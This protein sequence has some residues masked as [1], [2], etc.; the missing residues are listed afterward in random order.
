[1]VGKRRRTDL[2]IGGGLVV[3]LL[4]LAGCEAPDL[5]LEPESPGGPALAPPPVPPP[6]LYSAHLLPDLPGGAGAKALDI[7]DAGTVVGWADQG[8]EHRAVQWSLGTVTALATPTKASYGDP[9]ILKVNSVAHGINASGVAV[10]YYE[11]DRGIQG[12][13]DTAVRWINSSGFVRLYGATGKPT[14]A[15]AINGSGTVVGSSGD[16]AFRWN[17]A[18]QGVDL[19]PPGAIASVANDINDAGWA[20]GTATGTWGTHAYL[21]PPSGS[22]LDLTPFLTED[23]SYG[24]GINAAAVVVGSVTQAAT[25]EAFRRQGGFAILTIPSCTGATRFAEKVSDLGRVA[26]RCFQPNMMVRAWTLR[27]TA[28]QLLPL[29]PAAGWSEAFGVNGCGTVVGAAS[30][31]AV[32]WLRVACDK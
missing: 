27:G 32:L 10:G 9:G 21:W 25:I 19:H 1:M 11:V 30:D 24:H 7:N 8:I 2:A 26:G 18:G 12:K 23:R 15:Y 5:P 31:R 13:S 29:P 16:H 28:Q 4:A 22:P 3:L 17:A 6:P 14:F 20:V